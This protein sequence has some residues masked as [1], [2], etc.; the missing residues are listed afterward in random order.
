MLPYAR[1][2]RGKD[3]PKSL[4]EAKLCLRPLQ[5]STMFQHP[6]LNA[7]LFLAD[8]ISEPSIVSSTLPPAGRFCLILLI[9]PCL[10]TERPLSRREFVYFR[11]ICFLSLTC[12]AKLRSLVCFFL[13]WYHKIQMTH[14]TTVSGAETAQ[15]IQ[16]RAESIVSAVGAFQS[17]R[18]MQ[19]MKRQT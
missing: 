5:S 7:S 10:E 3:S 17:N 11:A 1:S 15:N 8:S 4:L 13:C 14:I 19:R 18:G 12:S 2:V 9:N 16:N 6:L